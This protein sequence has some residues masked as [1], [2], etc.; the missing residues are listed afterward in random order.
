MRLTSL[1]I[2]LAALGTSWVSAAPANPP[3]VV[4]L[5]VLESFS[6]S[7]IQSI[8]RMR[9]AYEA[10][11]YYAIGENERR[12]N[13]CGYSMRIATEY[14]DN[15]D[16]LAPKERA[17]YL[18]NSGVFL[19]L[20]PRR[21]EQ[22]IVAAH[23]V[24]RTPLISTAAS[25]D[26]V[27]QLAPPFFTMYPPIEKFSNA[28]LKALEKEKY[29][30]RYGSVVD[31]TCLACRDFENKFDKAAPAKKMVK[32]FGLEVAGEKP[33][34]KPLIEAIQKNQIDF[35]FLPVYAKGA[36]YIIANLQSQ[37][38][39]LKF[40]GTHSWGD[41]AYGLM[42]DYKVNNRVRAVAVN[43]NASPEVMGEVYNVYS[44]D[45]ETRSGVVGPPASAY[46]VVEFVRLLT[47]DLCERAARKKPRL[48][49]KEDF[50][51]YYK[52]LPSDRFHRKAVLG[53]FK[54]E[55]GEYQFSYRISP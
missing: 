54:I 24:N 34:L 13:R 7:E 48:K 18:E 25:S 30:S 23:G 28:L 43:S 53:I 21:S 51:S 16:K 40:A 37:F 32:V 44:L 31:V 46:R 29:G 26:D 33:D 49:S 1:F 4:R 42:E 38:P 22:F 52:T 5:G 20:G 19:I 15:A 39:N 3:T 35:L 45:R 11:L 9:S 14:Y 6:V 50:L 55:N 8:E 47:D 10:A 36:G 12:L 27:H 41:A 2:L 17:S